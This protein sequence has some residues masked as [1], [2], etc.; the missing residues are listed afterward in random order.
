MIKKSR[1]ERENEIKKIEIIRAAEKVFAAGGYHGTTMAQISQ[2]SE[3]PLG[4]IYKFFSGKEQIY[5]DLVF[6]KGLELGDILVGI[7]R[8]RE[9]SPGSRLRESLSACANFCQG[10][11]NFIRI[12]ISER[13]NIDGALTPSLN[14]KINTLHARLIAL[15]Q[16]LF[17]EGIEKGEFRS[18]SSH[19]MAV[20]FTG[21]MTSIAWFWLT[22]EAG[23]P[24]KLESFI[25]TVFS[26]F[27]D[28][29][30]AGRVLE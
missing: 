10:N 9:T 16:E 21:I 8:N 28:G 14:R 12:Y 13:S 23:S 5:H 30:L 17:D 29:I 1:K 22:E 11:Q 20:M 18:C 27:T 15:Y 19:Q 4:T 26:I 3:Y 2:A 7:T 24:D 6:T 25:K